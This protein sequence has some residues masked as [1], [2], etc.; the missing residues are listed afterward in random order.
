LPIDVPIAFS[1]ECRAQLAAHGSRVELVDVGDLDHNGSNIAAT[2]E[3]LAWFTRL[4]DQR[5]CAADD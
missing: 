3:A 5:V 1:R 2:A 4:R